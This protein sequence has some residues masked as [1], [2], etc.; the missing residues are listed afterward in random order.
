[1]KGVKN[2]LNPILG[3]IFRCHWDFDDSSADQINS[4]NKYPDGF[5]QT[6]RSHYFAEQLSH[7]PPHSAFVYYNN[8]KVNQNNRVNNLLKKQGVAATGNIAPSYV[9]FYGNSAETKI[10]GTIRL[11]NQFFA[12]MLKSNSEFIYLIQSLV[13]R[14]TNLDSRIYT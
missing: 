3:E 12:T 1:M 9:K 13:K 7:H 5:G 4:N 10:R 8:E 2:P 11:T 14:F 6:T